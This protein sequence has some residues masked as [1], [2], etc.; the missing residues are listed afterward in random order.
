MCSVREEIKWNIDTF[1]SIVD[2]IR[3]VAMATFTGY[4]VHSQC[5]VGKFRVMTGIYYTFLIR[6]FTF[7]MLSAWSQSNAD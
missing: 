1:V 3:L 5:M 4:S 6:L 2:M 7:V